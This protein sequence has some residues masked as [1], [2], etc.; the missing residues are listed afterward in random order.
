VI[1]ATDKA[2]ANKP[3]DLRA[4]VKGW[5]ETIAYMRAHKTKT[6][7]IAQ[8]V[9]HTNAPTTAAIYDEVMPMF[10]DDGHFDAQSLAVLRHSFVQMKILPSEPDM[11]KLYTEALLPKD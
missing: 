11:G 6:I 5:F 7:E 2:M 10:T 1:F 9:M 3:D 4:F 8:T